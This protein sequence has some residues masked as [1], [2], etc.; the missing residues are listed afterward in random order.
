MKLLYD[1]FY[2][3]FAEDY[4]NLAFISD[5]YLCAIDAQIRCH[6]ELY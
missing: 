2:T 3:V 4:L 1:G 5:A 6:S